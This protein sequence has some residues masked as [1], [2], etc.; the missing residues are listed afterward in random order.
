MSEPCQS[1][2]PV[3]KSEQTGQSGFTAPQ[4]MIPVFKC[5]FCPEEFTIKDL[6][7]HHVGV[8]H[9]LS[10]NTMES[11]EATTS[12]NTPTIPSDCDTNQHE[13]TSS[14]PFGKFQCDVCPEYFPVSSMLILHKRTHNKIAFG[15][16]ICGKGFK[17][18]K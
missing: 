3:I 9:K 1:S 7:V 13:A 8:S 15:C 17:D 10:P 18:K 4:Q 16:K 11:E 6:L 12:T 2:T 5:E 14:V